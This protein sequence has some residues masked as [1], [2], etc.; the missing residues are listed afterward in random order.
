ML[1]RIH[2]HRD[3]L[4]EALEE[5]GIPFVIRNL[6]ILDHPLVRDLLAYLRLLARPSDNVACARVLAA[7]AWGLEPADLV[8]LC[9]RAAKARTSLWDALQSA[10]GELPFQRPKPRADR[11]AG[12][13]NHGIARTRQR[14]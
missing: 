12:R 6:T 7:P 2:A 13:R 11:R 10:Q 3:E 5:R 9:E 4:V 1:Y 14:G 8:R